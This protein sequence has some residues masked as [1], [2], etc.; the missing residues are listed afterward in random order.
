MVAYENKVPSIP[1]DFTIISMVISPPAKTNKFLDVI[2]VSLKRRQYN[3]SVLKRGSFTP[4]V[5]NINRETELPNTFQERTNVL[6]K[7]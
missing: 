6:M 2:P 3:A 1:S 7:L 5:L 4:P